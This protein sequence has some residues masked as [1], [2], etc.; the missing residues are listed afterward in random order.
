M[1]HAGPYPL[2][3]F[4][5]GPLSGRFRVPGDKSISH[6]ALMLG[7]LAS[8][9]TRIRG[10]LESE[11][12]IN[13]AHAVTA[14]GAPAEQVGIVV[15]E[16]LGRGTGGLAQPAAPLDFGNAGTGSRLDDGRHRVA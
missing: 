9:K 4:H 16:V 15:W 1:T 12:V 8:G 13:T 7:A 6:R 5:S 11:D 14:L 3:A 2:A 10:L